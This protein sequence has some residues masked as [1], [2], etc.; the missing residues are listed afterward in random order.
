MQEFHQMQKEGKSLFIV[1]RTNSA[2]VY[3]IYLRCSKNTNFGTR[4][5][6]SLATR[7]EHQEMNHVG[8]RGNFSAAKTQQKSHL[9]QYELTEYLSWRTI[10]H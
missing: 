7:P 5:V 9:I 8:L 6:W 10:V 1:M 3:I 2:L 4:K